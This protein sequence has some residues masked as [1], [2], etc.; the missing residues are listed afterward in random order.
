[1]GNSIK[2][3]KKGHIQVMHTNNVK[4]DTLLVLSHVL[5]LLESAELDAIIVVENSVGL[6]T[7]TKL[8]SKVKFSINSVFA[9]ADS[10][11]KILPNVITSFGAIDDHL[12]LHISL[13][14]TSSDE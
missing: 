13:L 2:C 1:M 11:S 10:T 6:V 4:G 3:T 8:G 14:T 12:T 9:A 7:L 5:V